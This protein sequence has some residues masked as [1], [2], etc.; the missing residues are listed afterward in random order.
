MRYL[1]VKRTDK[2]SKMVSELIINKCND[3]NFTYISEKETSTLKDGEKLDIVF[4][5]GGDGTFLR[6]VH[7]YHKFNPIFININTGTFGYL[8]EFKIDEIEEI[9]PRLF[10]RSINYKEV[11]LLRLDKYKFKEESNSFSLTNSYF[12][13]NEFRIASIDEATIK[14]DIYID[15]TFLECLRGDGCVISSSLG[16]SGI[17]KSLKGALVDNEIE[18]LE[19]VEN[20]PIFNKKYHSISSPF[21]LNKDKEFK[22]TNFFHHS[23]NVYYDCESLR[24]NNFTKDDYISIYL[25]QSNKIRI[26]T[27]PKTNYIEKTREM[28]AN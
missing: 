1:I 28:F 23:F 4:S 17:T 12:A 9:F 24:V 14:F 6:S 5:I 19:F 20:A 25:D 7:Y 11:S 21:V 16:S 8:C 18:M 13:L 10:Q 3:C 22:L 27:N 2:I 26:L 15:N